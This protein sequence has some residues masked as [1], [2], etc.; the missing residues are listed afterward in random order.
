MLRNMLKR[1]CSDEELLSYLDGELELR[2]EV[3]VKAH[4]Q[5]C[6]ACRRRAGELENT[7]WALAKTLDEADYPTPQWIADAKLRL[8]EGARRIDRESTARA[9]P[10]FPRWRSWNVP[11]LASAGLLV[12][13]LSLGMWLIRPDSDPLPVT[14]IISLVRDA[15]AEVRRASVQQEFRVEID[16]IKPVPVKVRSRLR[17]VSDPARDR[18]VS[19]WLG[20]ADTLRHAVYRPRRGRAYVYDARAAPEA[21]KQF[22]PVPKPVSLVSLGEDGL[23][24]QQIEAAFMR[25]L[26]SRQWQPLSFAPDLATFSD[27]E[28]VVLLAE[29]AW[30]RD[31]REVL[32]ISAR[33]ADGNRF[34][35]ILIEV[36][37]S[38]HRP[39]VH[40]VRFETPQQVLR[41]RIEQEEFEWISTAALKPS[42]FEPEF[43]LYRTPEPAIANRLAEEPK[44]RAI[45]PAPIAVAPSAIE[46]EVQHALHLADA[47][48]G[49]PIEIV[50]EPN[51]SLVVRGIVNTNERR[52]EL[53]ALFDNLDA[54]PWLTHD[55]STVEEMVPNVGEGLGPSAP[56]TDRGV[57]PGSELKDDLTLQ[58][59]A[60]RIPIQDQMEQYFRA[61][62][63]DSALTLGERMSRYAGEL[64]TQSGD[65]LAHA[66]ALRRLMERY[67]PGTAPQQSRW[68][69]LVEAML[70]D[71]STA[72]E[73]TLSRLRGM[74]EPVLGARD[75]A[76]GASRPRGLE[77][78]GRIEPASASPVGDIAEI[79]AM[80]KRIR[81]RVL[82]L[83]APSGSMVDA[84]G[85]GATAP[86]DTGTADETAGALLRDLADIEA[87]TRQFRL[88]H[89]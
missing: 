53:I 77:I 39:Q 2:K 14:E 25:W 26:E 86:S 37:P 15:E 46:V 64:V 11:A 60:E 82:S 67:P 85:A 65:A 73:M 19:R 42:I 28:G 57:G 69:R 32:R 74:V 13:L 35:E 18:F 50:R 16:Q 41:I 66:W 40:E 58:F 1:H 63:A 76:V 54:D 4:L 80:G 22:G 61:S 78:P 45:E 29:R 83:F 3:A 79:L 71:H 7:V 87:A 59:T 48:M 20:P 34:V 52:A 30:R 88:L 72:L 56:T 62:H 89:L 6:W 23:T 33:Q 55:L 10:G 24:V 8:E 12:L 84:G 70:R 75:A 31:G 21:V 43:P 27:S 5:S 81:H 36:D 51:G 47:C 49:D 68:P 38:T 44:S 17:V 9:Q